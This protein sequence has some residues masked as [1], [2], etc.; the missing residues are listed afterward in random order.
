M[1]TIPCIAFAL[2]CIGAPDAAAQ[3]R[4]CVTPEGAAVYTDRRCEALGATEQ[5]VT[6]ERAA[7]AVHRGG[8]TR[9]LRD[10]M[11]ELGA[12]IDANDPNRLAGLYHWTGMSTR[13]AYEV[14]GRLD[15]IAQRPLV[16]IVP[17]MPGMSSD[18]G[19]PGAPTQR[20]PVGLRL[21]QTLANGL[22]AS[23][24]VFGLQRH[25]GCWWIRG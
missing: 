22:T 5:P 24:A 23:H 18:A 1:R 19:Y 13:E 4:H 6:H 17:L 25:Y 10:L 8:C 3:V 9:T 20:E 16:D 21:E 14:I 2:A 15:A 11:F 7:V 12:A